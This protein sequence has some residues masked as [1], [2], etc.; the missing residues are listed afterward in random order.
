M[1]ELGTSILNTFFGR[2][3]SRSASS[4]TASVL[5]G[6]NTAYK[7]KA[8]ADRAEETL[9]QLQIDLEDLETS[10]RREIDEMTTQFDVTRVELESVVITPRKS[11]LK[12]RP[13][14]FLWV[15]WQVDPQG[16]A[17]PMFG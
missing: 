1:I 13:L 4:R 5:R 7:K 8:D 11:D 14:V 9:R 15:P 17:E 12:T 10:L 16:I 3:T 6:A 2:K